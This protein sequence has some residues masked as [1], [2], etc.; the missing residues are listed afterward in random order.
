VEWKITTQVSPGQREPK[1]SN[2]ERRAMFNIQNILSKNPKLPAYVLPQVG[3]S[4]SNMPKYIE[5]I[6]KST[7][8]SP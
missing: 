5:T 7:E 8:N 2:R 1:Y 3:K 4:K 6:D